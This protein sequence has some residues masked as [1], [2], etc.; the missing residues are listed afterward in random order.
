MAEE[1]SGGWYEY[2]KDKAHA[3]IDDLHDRI[4]FDTQ[5]KKDET[6]MA[7][8][9]YAEKNTEETSKVKKGF[10]TVKDK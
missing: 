8:P 10:Q 5:H 3:A 1:N 9:N 7:D 6:S 2:L 4:V